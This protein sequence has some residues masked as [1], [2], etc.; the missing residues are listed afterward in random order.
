MPSERN[1]S[2]DPHGNRSGESSGATAEEY[3]PD[4]PG[5]DYRKSAIGCFRVN[6]V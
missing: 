2:S 5:L 1:T 3:W 6:E 4:M